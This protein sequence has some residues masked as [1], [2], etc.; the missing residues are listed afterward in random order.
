MWQ[1]ISYEYSPGKLICQANSV[2]CLKIRNALQAV[3]EKTKKNTP[4]IEMHITS[5]DESNAVHVISEK[6]LI[7]VTKWESALQTQ[8]VTGDIRSGKVFA[9]SH[10]I[11]QKLGFKMANDKLISVNPMN[12]LRTH[13]CAILCYKNAHGGRWLSTCMSIA[14]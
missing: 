5:N 10:R 4:T 8:G 7:C 13:L 2:D 12:E 11:C 3:A 1:K 14:V 6:I 9:L